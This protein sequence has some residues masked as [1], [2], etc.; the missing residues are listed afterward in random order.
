MDSVAGQEA[1]AVKVLQ[2]L[3][4]T[5]DDASQH[6]PLACA[7][8]PYKISTIFDHLL[9]ALVREAVEPKS[10]CIRLVTCDTGNGV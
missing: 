4:G 7:G 3:D 8:V 9:F 10:I 6:T 1:A 2:L 5:V